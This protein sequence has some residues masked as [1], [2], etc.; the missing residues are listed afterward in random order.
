[1]LDTTG[2]G[3]AFNGGFRAA[4]VRGGNPR[5]ALRLANDIGARSTEAIGGIA[6]G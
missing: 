3:D 4:L 5:A 1:V 2:A 6:S